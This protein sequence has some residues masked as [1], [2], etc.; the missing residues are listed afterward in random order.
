MCLRVFVRDRERSEKIRNKKEEKRMLGSLFASGVAL[1]VNQKHK[2]FPPSLL[3]QVQIV[4]GDQRH[5]T[6]TCTPPPASR[7]AVFFPFS[8][9]FF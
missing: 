6:N 8:P 2:V 4:W 1:H 9:P 3:L 5:S 7:S